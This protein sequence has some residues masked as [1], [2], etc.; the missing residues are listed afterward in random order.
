M[1]HDVGCATGAYLRGRTPPVA[2]NRARHGRQAIM[3]RVFVGLAIVAVPLWAGDLQQARQFYARLEYDAAWRALG[4]ADSQDPR[5]LLLQGQIAYQRGQ[6]KDAVD[7]LKQAAQL[8]PDHAAI[9]LWLG[10]S[11]GQRAKRVSLR[12]FT[13]AQRC[14]EA[15]ERAVALDPT[16]VDALYDLA[17]YHLKAPSFLGGDVGKA[18]QLAARIAALDAATGEYIQARM[19]EARQEFSRAE[20]HLRRAVA[21]APDS[22]KMLFALAELH[23]QR[24][25]NLTE[26]RALLHRYLQ[27]PLTP[28]D[29]PRRDAERLLANAGG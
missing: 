25:H 24:Q 19:A 7:R 22:P 13:L 5:V 21:L 23:I 29:P 3:W 17:S 27:M 26:A 12:P 8:A 15:L 10:R 4:T 20:A 9:F 11:L 1:G 6:Y 28:E 2:V 16:Q 14:R 18:E